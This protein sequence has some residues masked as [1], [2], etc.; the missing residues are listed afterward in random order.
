MTSSEQTAAGDG[1]TEKAVAADE[2]VGMDVGKIAGNGE[3]DGEVGEVG[4]VGGDN[5]EREEE[6][7]AAVNS[8]NTRLTGWR[9]V[10]RTS[11]RRQ[12]KS[13]PRQTSRKSAASAAGRITAKRPPGA[14][15]RSTASRKSSYD[16]L[17]A[18]RAVVR[19]SSGQVS[20]PT[21]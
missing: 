12:T 19:P 9:G 7:A 18:W 14:N 5:G 3:E 20:E 2:D 10:V 21:K 8:N 17:T 16:R 4:E 15:K 1:A 11:V 13:R 6:A